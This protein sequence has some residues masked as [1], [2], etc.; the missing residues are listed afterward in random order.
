MTHPNVPATEVK[1]EPDPFDVLSAELHR[2]ADDIAAMV[3]SGLPRPRLFQLNIQPGTHDDD[4]DLTARSVDGMAQALL[5]VTGK[6]ERM[7]SG[8]YFYNTDHL[9][10]GP[11][12]ITIYQGVSTEWALKNDVVAAK[13]ELAERE[14]E[15]EKARARVA[16]LER[17]RKPLVSDETIAEAGRLQGVWNER[18]ERWESTADD[19]SGFGYSR[20][21]DDPT[22]VSPARGVA[23]TGGV[24]GVAKPTTIRADDGG[25]LVTDP[26]AQ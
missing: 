13:A 8:T 17:A 25:V 21:A 24:E 16:E 1:S 19:P 2:V 18:E 26:A 3:G 5:G 15:L 9:K 11:L 10:R 6:V 4:D 12:E 20:E 7:S 22:P 23:H 14:A